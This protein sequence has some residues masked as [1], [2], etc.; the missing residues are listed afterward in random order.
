M[1]NVPRLRLLVELHHR[2]TLAEVAR[3]LSYTP[4]AVSQ[5]LSLLE[6][7]VGARLLEPVGRRVVLTDA[8]LRLVS[9]AEVVLRQLE[10]AESELAAASDAVRGTLRVASFQ[11]VVFAIVPAVLDLLSDTAPGL[12][13]EFD[14]LQVDAAYSGLLSH[15]FDLIL[16]EEYPGIPTPVRANVDRTDLVADALLLAVPASRGWPTDGVEALAEVP[17]A[18]DPAQSVSGD[19]ARAVCRT[20]GFEPRARFVSPD[21]LMHAHLVRSGHAA[22]FIPSLITTEQSDGL[23][24]IELPG[25]PERILYTAVRAGRGAHPAV[26][27]FREALRAASEA[28]PTV[29]PLA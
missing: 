19:W 8:A 25:R 6:R 12:R 9:H 5:Q 21:P 14:Q 17:W 13:I 18:L 24:L 22:A 16:G 3:A 28:R 29:R 20:A 11:T 2:G 4:S 10:E 23:E 27:A 1:L 15:E 7:E 26:R